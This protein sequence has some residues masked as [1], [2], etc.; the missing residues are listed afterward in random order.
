MQQRNIVIHSHFMSIK[1]FSLIDVIFSNDTLINKDNKLA[2]LRYVEQMPYNTVC[3]A[4]TKFK[5]QLFKES[6]K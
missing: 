6:I 2:F 5:T 1:D 3:R 4:C